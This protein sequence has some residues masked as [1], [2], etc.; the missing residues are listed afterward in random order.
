MK[1]VAKLLLFV[2]GLNLILFS[3]T[4]EPLD[5]D[6][7]NNTALTDPPVQDADPPAEPNG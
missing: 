1:N 2:L 5:A 3:C 6:G 4:A 7:I